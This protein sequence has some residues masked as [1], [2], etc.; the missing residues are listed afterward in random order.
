MDES[1]TRPASTPFPARF[2]GALTNRQPPHRWPPLLD[3]VRI[4]VMLRH[5]D[6][7]PGGVKA[8]THR[9]LNALLARDGHEYVFFYQGPEVLGTFAAHDRVL[10]MALPSPSRIW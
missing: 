5:L 9:L 1:G 8:Y 6:Q 2:P 10:E 3:T 4:G 7:H